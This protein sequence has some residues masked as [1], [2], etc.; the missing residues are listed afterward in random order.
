VSDLKLKFPDRDLQVKDPRNPKYTDGSHEYSIDFKLVFFQEASEL[1][2]EMSQI[3]ETLRGQLYREF[4]WFLF[5]FM[6][7]Y[8]TL[9]T[10]M[11]IEIAKEIT[12]PVI[13]LYMTLNHIME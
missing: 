12:E 1:L 7:L 5:I 9:M 6:V 13:E 11:L 2:K 3:K 8:I 10:I 4:S